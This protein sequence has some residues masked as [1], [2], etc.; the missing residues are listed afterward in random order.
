MVLTIGM[1]VGF[2]KCWEP[3]MFH[4]APQ[5]LKVLCEKGLPTPQRV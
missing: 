4:V 1:Q 5:W 2:P 3:P